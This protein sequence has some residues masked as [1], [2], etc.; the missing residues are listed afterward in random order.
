MGA[1][2]GVQSVN[3]VRWGWGGASDPNC[4]QLASHLSSSALDFTFCAD[5]GQL[6]K[7]LV[8]PPC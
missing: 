8:L 2:S 7:S 5:P 6:E 1:E 4:G 3:K